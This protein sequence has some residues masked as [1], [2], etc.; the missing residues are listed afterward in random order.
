MADRAFQTVRR[1]GA[2]ARAFRNMADRRSVPVVRFGSRR[3][4]RDVL[5]SRTRSSC[6]LTRSRP[7]VTTAASCSR[8]SLNKGSNVVT[9]ASMC[10]ASAKTRFPIIAPVKPPRS[11][12]ARQVNGLFHLFIAR[13][14]H[15]FRLTRRRRR[16]VCVNRFCRGN[17]RASA[18]SGRHRRG[19]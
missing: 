14:S 4:W 7:S 13:V 9:A 10:T 6:T 3:R 11:P 2:R 17:G 8:A 19:Q 1:A 12:A 5:K 15:V 18:R 16:V